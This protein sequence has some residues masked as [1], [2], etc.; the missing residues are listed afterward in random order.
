MNNKFSDMAVLSSRGARWVTEVKDEIENAPRLETSLLRLANKAATASSILQRRTTIGVFG[1]SQ[2]GKSYLVNTLAAGGNDLTCSWGGERIEFMTHINPN[3]GDKE[4]TGAVTRFTHDASCGIK[5]FPVTIRVF[6][7]CEIALIL[8][9]SFYADFTVKTDTLKELDERFKK[10]NYDAFFKELAADESLLCKDGNWAVS[11]E[12]LVYA[13]DYVHEH[14]KGVLATLDADGDFWLKMRDLAPR[15]NASGLTRLFSLLWGNMAVLNALFEKI[16]REIMKLEGADTVYTGLD[17]FVEP[18]ADGGYIQHADGTLLSISTLAKLFQDTRRI[19]V[20]FKNGGDV[21]IAELSFCAMAAAVMELQFP[22]EED[23]RLENFDVLDFPGARE[24]RADSAEAFMEKGLTQETQ[25]ASSEFLRR[26]KVAY[27]FDR[28]SQDREVDLLLFCINSSAQQEVSSLVAILNSW[29]DM[30]AGSSAQERAAHKEIPL[31]GVLTRFDQQMEKV[32]NNAL[33]GRPLEACSTITTA[34]EHFRNCSWLNEWTCGEEHKQ[35]FLV[36]RP[37]MGGIFK[38]E[39]GKETGIDENYAPYLQALGED[40]ARDPNV[41]H[42]YYSAERSLSEVLKLDDGGAG[43]IL[44]FIADNFT[45]YEGSRERVEESVGALLKK[46]IEALTLYQSGSGSEA[47]ARSLERG[48]ELADQF[49]Q[50]V[51]CVQNESFFGRMR[52]Y[53][54]LDTALLSSIYVEDYA[55]GQNAARFAA[56]SLAKQLEKL[57]ALACDPVLTELF[58]PLQEKWSSSRANIVAD[59]ANELLHRQYSLF[60]DDEKHEFFEAE[61]PK[62][63]ERFDL[64]MQNYVQE[65]EKALA[66]CAVEDKLRD[67][68]DAIEREITDLS[69]LSTIQPRVVQKILSSFLLYL[70]YDEVGNIPQVERSSLFSD[71]VDEERLFIPKIK[72][73]QEEDC[74]MHRTIKTLPVLD[75]EFKKSCGTVFFEDHLCALVN[76][77]TG[78]NLTAEGRYKFSV[79][80]SDELNEI[81]KGLEATR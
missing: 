4:A 49:M 17:A 22:L 10:E 75:T 18:K 58:I 81:L 11:R 40:F 28:Y 72:L 8:C 2:A 55:Y 59:S 53:C 34:L 54:E 30:N 50:C 66:G 1:A 44:Q 27:L 61:D 37:G 12:D 41:S 21:K 51:R 31:I 79:A 16:C 23:S 3:G 14:A 36:R 57:R 13:A 48:R 60:Y 63:K 35:F 6:K 73:T 78:V 5:D 26:G 56:Q 33:G 38:V 43:A 25:N 65:L 76:R 19:R 70:G 9:N 74:D 80:Q 69:M 68:L 46:C 77:M 64:L 24:R 32:L 42:L 7:V 67:A 71:E 52:E 45:G 62:L 15:L 29:I 47:L 20:A 39:G